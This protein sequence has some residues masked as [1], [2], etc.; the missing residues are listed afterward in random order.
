MGSVVVQ[1]LRRAAKQHTYEGILT[2][3]IG[4]GL[5][6]A[7]DMQSIVQALSANRLLLDICICSLMISMSGDLVTNVKKRC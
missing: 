3:G 4:S 5:V 6:D 7:T 1:R 2:L